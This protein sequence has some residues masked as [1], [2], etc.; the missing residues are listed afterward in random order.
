MGV[1]DFLMQMV[2][3]ILNMSLTASAV[4]LVVLAVRWLLR[5]APRMT[6]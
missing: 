3:E 1:K 2:P 5:S 4:I 6:P